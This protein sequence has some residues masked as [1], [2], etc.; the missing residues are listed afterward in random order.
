MTQRAQRI[1][2]DTARLP[3]RQLIGEKPHKLMSLKQA[4]FPV[5][6]FFTVISDGSGKL[7]INGKLERAFSRLLEPEKI[8]RSAHPLEG[9]PHSFSGV[10]SSLTGATTV[11]ELA[12]DYETIVLES[13][14]ERTEYMIS[15]KVGE[16]LKRYGIANFNPNDMNLLVMDYRQVQ[17][18]GMFLTSDQARPNETVIQY[19]QYNDG[20]IGIGGWVVY[21]RKSNSL[22]ITQRFEPGLERAL[23]EFGRLAQGVEE[24]FGAVQQVEFGLTNGR[25]EVFQSRDFNFGDPNSA[26]RF[27]HYKTFSTQLRAAGFGYH[28]LPV[29][30]LDRL[31]NINSSFSLGDVEGRER[32]IRQYKQEIQAFLSANKEYIVF[33]KDAELFVS[34]KP[35][36][37]GCDYDY[38]ELNEI[39]RNAKVVFRGENQNAIRHKQWDNVESGGINISSMGDDPIGNMFIHNNII[40]D[41]AK[42]RAGDYVNP[43]LSERE[44]PPQVT[45]LPWFGTVIKT[46]D[47]IHV[48]ANI[49][50][51]FVWKD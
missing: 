15:R 43:D 34:S 32:A 38:D 13:N 46:G 12:E 48:L 6:D 29:L 4:G 1:I 39:S 28:H 10:F 5:P 19:Q 20:E 45:L 24:H 22:N 30:V 14:P 7:T 42:I 25:A 21:D 16:Y 2:L 23:V 18:F 27:S 11:R 35:E 36:S 47:R 51:T 8:A 41:T 3:D 31:E 49:D 26:P 50:G 37:S 9:N 17:V 44:I 40:G 33:I